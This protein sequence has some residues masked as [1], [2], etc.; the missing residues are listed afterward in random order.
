V[1]RR[2]KSLG[3]FFFFINPVVKT[4]LGWHRF[5][6]SAPPT[7]ASIARQSRLAALAGDFIDDAVA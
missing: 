5:S 7:V 3:Q 4:G 1:I 6:L 2:A